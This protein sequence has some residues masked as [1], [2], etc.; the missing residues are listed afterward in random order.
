VSATFRLPAAN[1]E[2]VSPV[3]VSIHV[4]VSFVTLKSRDNEISIT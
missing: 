3:E 4:L 2:E 1:H